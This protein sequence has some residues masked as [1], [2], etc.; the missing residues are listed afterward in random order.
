MTDLHTDGTESPAWRWGSSADLTMEEE[1]H[2]KVKIF[3]M[4]SMIM[5]YT[6]HENVFGVARM[7]TNDMRQLGNLL[8]EGADVMEQR[9]T[10]IV[11]PVSPNA[12]KESEDG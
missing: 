4:S 1:Y 11:P 2:D 8:I 12:H 6:Y 7:T 3:A 10:D 9:L 5:L